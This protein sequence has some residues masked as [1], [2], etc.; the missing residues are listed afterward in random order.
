[1]K[2]QEIRNKILKLFVRFHVISGEWIISIGESDNVI[3][4]WGAY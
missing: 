1:M 4:V 3:K 2:I